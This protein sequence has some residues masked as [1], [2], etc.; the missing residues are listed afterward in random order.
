M[1][2]KKLIKKAKNAY[3]KVMDKQAE[4]PYQLQKKLKEG[5]S[6][7]RK[8]SKSFNKF[9]KGVEKAKKGISKAYHSKAVQKVGKGLDLLENVPLLGGELRD[10]RQLVKGV[11][12]DPFA[13]KSNLLNLVKVLPEAKA[14]QEVSDLVFGEAADYVFDKA[15]DS[16]KK[17]EK[18][19]KDR[20]FNKGKKGNKAIKNPSVNQNGLNIKF[21]KYKQNTNTYTLASTLSGAGKP[22]SSMRTSGSSSSIFH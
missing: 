17:R 10:V 20:V 3:N 6:Y 5:W 12:K 9:A 13:L 22:A 4:A 15:G 21:P 18:R 7:G 16:L 2:L 8:N 14:E 11:I 1:G 19:A